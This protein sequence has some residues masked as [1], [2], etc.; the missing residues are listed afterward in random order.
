MPEINDVYRRV[1]NSPM[2]IKDNGEISSAI[3]LDSRGVSVDIDDSRRINDIIADEERIH[4]HHNEEKLRMDPDGPYKLMAIVSVPKDACWEKS[5]QIELEPV[6]D[7]PYHAILKRLKGKIE[8]TGSQR[9]HLRDNSKIVKMY[10]DGM[11]I[12][13]NGSCK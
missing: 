3:Y 11:V 7:N 6:E 4:Q 10:Q 2:Y 5:V 9:K 13:K 1:R 12:G 8:L